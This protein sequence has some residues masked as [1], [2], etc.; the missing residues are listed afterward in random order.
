M[1]RG[2][3]RHV[4]RSLIVMLVLAQWAIMSHACM[5]FARAEQSTFIAARAATQAVSD[6][7]LA[8][9]DAGHPPDCASMESLSAYGQ[10]I[11]CAEHCKVGT[12]GDQS[13]AVVVPAVVLS[14]LYGVKPPTV[15]APPSRRASASM[16][17][18]LA[19]ASPPH[20]ILHCV[21]RT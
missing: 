15:V 16:A 7:G 9:T 12:Q 10:D 14:A 2:P 18:A 3:L 6:I 17:S 20:A 8:V 21:R 5:A 4:A 1:T 13:S 19:L 11:L